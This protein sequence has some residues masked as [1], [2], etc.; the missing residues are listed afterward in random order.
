MLVKGVRGNKNKK[1]ANKKTVEKID[2]SVSE[3]CEVL[4]VTKRQSVFATGG[5]SKVTL[6]HTPY[7]A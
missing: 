7:F 6:H 2:R 3:Y 5:Y 4:F 1:S